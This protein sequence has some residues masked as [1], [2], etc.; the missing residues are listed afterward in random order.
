MRALQPKRARLVL[1]QQDATAVMA[2]AESIE[3]DGGE[4]LACRRCH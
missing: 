4:V 3:R 2:G 1:S